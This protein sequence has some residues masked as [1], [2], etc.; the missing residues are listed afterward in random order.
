MSFYQQRLFDDETAIRSTGQAR[1]LV[2]SF[3]ENATANLTGGMRL[4]T[5]SRVTVCPDLRLSYPIRITNASETRRG[6]RGSEYSGDKYRRINDEADQSI[7]RAAN[8]RRL[9]SCSTAAQLRRELREFNSRHIPRPTRRVA[10]AISIRPTYIECKA[11]GRGNQVILYRERLVKEEAWL[12]EQNC[13]IIYFIWCH[14]AQVVSA[15]T[16]ETLH[17]R[18]I[19]QTHSVIIISSQRIHQLAR[20][21]RLRCVN[22][23]VPKKKGGVPVKEDNGRCRYADETMG[24]TLPTSIIRRECQVMSWLFVGTK[25]ANPVRIYYHWTVPYTET[26]KFFTE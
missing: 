24:W 19:N 23:G 3:Y 11:A 1:C 6:N 15:T 14:N 13:N 7:G 18:L 9:W 16:T 4:K 17:S 25:F 2:G 22:H 26:L 20:S 10:N 5:D 8:E 12:L 21:R